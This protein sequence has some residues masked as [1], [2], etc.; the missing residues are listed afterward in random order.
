MHLLT[1]LITN[2]HMKLGGSVPLAIKYYLDDRLE[3]WTGLNSIIT[4]LKMK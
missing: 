3:T 4:L 1:L 2:Q